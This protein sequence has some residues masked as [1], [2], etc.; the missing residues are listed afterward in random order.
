MLSIIY[1]QSDKVLI[2]FDVPDTS[3]APHLSRLSNILLC[4]QY[5]IGKKGKELRVQ[6]CK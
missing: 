4:K 1:K 2:L 5:L 3:K 6:K